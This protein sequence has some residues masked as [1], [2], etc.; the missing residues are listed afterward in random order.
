MLFKPI[1]T[2]AAPAWTFT[3]NIHL[4]RIRG[5]KVNHKMS[6]VYSNDRQAQQTQHRHQYEHREKRF[7]QT[8]RYVSAHNLKAEYL[9]FTRHIRFTH[10][11]LFLL[12]IG[13]KQPYI[14]TSEG[15]RTYRR[16]QIEL[17]YAKKWRLNVSFTITNTYKLIVYIYIFVNEIFCV[18]HEKE[19]EYV[20]KKK[21]KPNAEFQL[22][23]IT[24]VHCKWLRNN[25]LW[26]QN[27]FR[28]CNMLFK[29][30]VLYLSNFIEHSKI[31]LAV[32]LAR[33]IVQSET[34]DFT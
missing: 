19:E 13:Y 8:T 25:N 21:L 4:N 10:N 26:P 15:Y 22:T 29:L 11:L 28:F 20:R 6:E 30:T 17:S 23:P 34:N 14:V 24:I 18:L 5:N 7:R 2:Y 32:L 16:R 3:A 31:G 12:V 1:L 33:S 9:K 27:V